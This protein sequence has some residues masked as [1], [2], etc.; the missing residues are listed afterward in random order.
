MPNVAFLVLL[1]LRKGCIVSGITIGS[2]QLLEE[3]V[4]FVVSKTLHLPVGKTPGFTLEEVK[5]AYDYLESGN[6]IWKV[7]IAL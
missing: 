5:A 1:V 4:Q 2:K 7:C 6:H 3:L